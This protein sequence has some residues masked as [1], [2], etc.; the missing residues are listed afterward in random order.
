MDAR[1]NASDLLPTIGQFENLSK[2]EF[3]AL[4]SGSNDVSQGDK[5]CVIDVKQAVITSYHSDIHGGN[6]PPLEIPSEFDMKLTKRNSQDDLSSSIFNRSLL[7]K[8]DGEGLSLILGRRQSSGLLNKL[9][10]QPSILKADTDS[11]KKFEQPV[12][13]HPFANFTHLAKLLVK[14]FKSEQIKKEDLKFLPQEFVLLKSVVQ[15][16]FNKAIKIE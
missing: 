14:F 6:L 1:A 8:D 11:E 12:E 10:W 5:N 2:F 9:A 3:R 13:Y 7:F 16:K 4:L 15:R